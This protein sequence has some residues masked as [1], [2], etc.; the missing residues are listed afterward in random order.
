[1]WG[2]D[3]V[4]MGRKMEEAREDGDENKKKGFQE[5]LKIEQVEV[6]SILYIASSFYIQS[7]VTCIEQ[8]LQIDQRTHASETVP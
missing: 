2:K 6:Q 3:R 5:A 4:E 1:M 7:I 8:Y